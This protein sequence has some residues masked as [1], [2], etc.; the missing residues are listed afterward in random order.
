MQEHSNRCVLHSFIFVPA[1]MQFHRYFLLLQK[2]IS[3]G[4]MQYTLIGIFQHNILNGKFV[5]QLCRFDQ[6][7]KKKTVIYALKNS[8]LHVLQRLIE[9][10]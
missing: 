9:Q 2:S 6:A 10:W 1:F 7:N 8:V 5:T 3:L 4:G